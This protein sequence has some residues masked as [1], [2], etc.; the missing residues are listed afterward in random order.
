VDIA[1]AITVPER[2]APNPTQQTREL[3]RLNRLAVPAPELE[4]RE[5][6]DTFLGFAH[7]VATPHP[8][9]QAWLMF[10]RHPDLQILGSIVSVFQFHLQMP[11]SGVVLLA[12]RSQ[13]QFL[14]PNCRQL[15][16]IRHLAL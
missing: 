8:W 4:T 3:N 2:G 9:S 15:P 6:R 12:A 7:G 5:S 11:D 14:V 10:D 1:T 13:C 16:A